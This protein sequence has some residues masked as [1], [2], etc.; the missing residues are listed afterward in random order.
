MWSGGLAIGPAYIK[1]GQKEQ[2]QQL[3]NAHLVVNHRSVV[4][5]S[6]PSNKY[7]YISVCLLSLL[8]SLVMFI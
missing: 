6:S 4:F 7:E 2:L 8:L 1:F 5:F 3:F